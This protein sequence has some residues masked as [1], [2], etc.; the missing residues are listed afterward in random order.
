MARGR[1]LIIAMKT[2]IR[3]SRLSTKNSRCEYQWAPQADPSIFLV[4]IRIAPSA[5]SQ[6]LA[7]REAKRDKAKLS[8]IS[9][10]ISS[11]SWPLS[12]EYG[13]H[14]TV[15]TRSW[16]WLSVKSRRNI[17]SCSLFDWKQ[18]GKALAFSKRSSE[19]FKWFP[20]R[21]EADRATA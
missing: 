10:T 8:T 4:Q 20:L 7:K 17:S 19:R 13:T 6:V 11:F 18:I 3:T 16:P 9:L 5:T 2:C 1:S 12:S 14:Q 15:K 21:L